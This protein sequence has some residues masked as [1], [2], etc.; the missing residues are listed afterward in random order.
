M[1][2]QYR[3]FVKSSLYQS[4][5]FARC[6]L[7]YLRSVGRRS[8]MSIRWARAAPKTATFDTAQVID[9]RDG[10]LSEYNEPVPHEVDETTATDLRRAAVLRAAALPPSRTRVAAQAAAA[11]LARMS[12]PGSGGGD[13]ESSKEDLT[14]EKKSALNRIGMLLQKAFN[15]V[16]KRAKAGGTH[17]T[18][19]EVLKEFEGEVEKAGAEGLKGLNQ[20]VEGIVVVA[21]ETVAEAGSFAGGTTVRLV[22]NKNKDG[23]YAEVVDENGK[24]Q[25]GLKIDG[26]E[27]FKMLLDQWEELVKKPIEERIAAGQKLMDD[28]EKEKTEQEQEHLRNPDFVKSESM[29]NSKFSLSQIKAVLPDAIADVQR[30][31]G[32]ENDPK[33]TPEQLS[34]VV[35]EVIS[36]MGVQQDET[37]SSLKLKEAVRSAVKS[38]SIKSAEPSLVS[39]GKLATVSSRPAPPATLLARLRPLE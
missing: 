3:L 31:M 38:S 7:I 8:G 21:G 13:K 19:P 26:Q 22:E 15:Q 5:G 39:Q 33:F 11:G 24:V 14:E 18:E 29:S 30:E 12:A 32:S 36:E 28:A 20:V 4:S 34:A 35:R 1:V 10:V 6:N 16:T 17:A 2:C 9:F 37:V 27:Y 25:Y 23:G